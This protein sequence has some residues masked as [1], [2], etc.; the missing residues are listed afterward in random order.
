MTSVHFFGWFMVLAALFIFGFKA[1]ITFDVARDPSS[2]G[3]VPT[4]DGVIFPP[5]F[6][7][8]GIYFVRCLPHQGRVWPAYLLLWLFLTLLASAIFALAS[9]AGEYY[10]KK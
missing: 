7:A 5:I 2:G 10:R 3:G 9:R 1:C 8:W 4:L 6:A